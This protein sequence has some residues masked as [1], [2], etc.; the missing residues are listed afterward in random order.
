MVYFSVFHG[1]DEGIGLHI[2]ERHFFSRRDG[3]GEAFL[4][5][6]GDGDGPEQILLARQRVVVA[7]A[8]PVCLAHEAIE[9]G[10]GADAQ[11]DQIAGFAA[12]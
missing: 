5:G 10:K 1:A 3:L 11:H 6:K 7:A 8:L 9:R 2:P 12:G 4:G